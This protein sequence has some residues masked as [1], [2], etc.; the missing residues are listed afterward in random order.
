MP[1]FTTTFLSCREATIHS[2]IIRNLMFFVPITP[3]RALAS[4]RVP[5]SCRSGNSII[6]IMVLRKNHAAF[7]GRIRLLERIMPAPTPN[8]RPRRARTCD[9]PSNA[10]FHPM[11]EGCI[12]L[13]LAVVTLFA[14]RFV[15]GAKQRQRLGAT[16]HTPATHRHTAH[17]TSRESNKFRLKRRPFW[18]GP[19]HDQLLLQFLVGSINVTYIARPKRPVRPLSRQKHRGRSF[20]RISKLWCRY[21]TDESVSWKEAA[22]SHFVTAKS[23]IGVVGRCG[24]Q[25][26]KRSACWLSCS[27][28]AHRDSVSAS[29]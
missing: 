26:W 18:I 11:D 22:T 24:C 28:R 3:E 9:F 21:Q 16:I 17:G 20:V 29:S 14:F 19:L 13:S 8:R 25:A 6:I 7:N 27:L 12:P 5:G 1:S 15:R 4:I 2:F 23:W 10:V